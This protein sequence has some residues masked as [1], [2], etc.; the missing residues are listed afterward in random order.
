MKCDSSHLSGYNL[1]RIEFEIY[2]FKWAILVGSPLGA[3]SHSH[4][5]LYNKE[6]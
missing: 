4:F 1:F 6:Y 3:W 5:I 2:R